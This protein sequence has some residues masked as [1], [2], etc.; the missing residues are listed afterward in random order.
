MMKK[1]LY[2]LMAIGIDG[3]VFCGESNRGGKLFYI[4]P[5]DDK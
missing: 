2:A 3:T 5:G 1:G 4:I